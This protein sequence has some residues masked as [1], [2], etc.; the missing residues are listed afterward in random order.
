MADL[1]SRKCGHKR[2]PRIDL[3]CARIATTDTSL[4]TTPRFQRLATE[5]QGATMQHDGT[6]TRSYIIWLCISFL[7]IYNV[8]ALASPKPGTGAG[9]SSIPFVPGLNAQSHPEV[10]RSE[11]S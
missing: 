8:L 2:Q 6:R 4:T 11:I 5:R 7:I 10:A 1:F 3:A 9:L